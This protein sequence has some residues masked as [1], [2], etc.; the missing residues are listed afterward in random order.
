MSTKNDNHAWFRSVSNAK[1][2]QTPDILLDNDFIR[3]VYNFLVSWLPHRLKPGGIFPRCHLIENFHV[4]CFC[5]SL[6]NTVS[7]S[8]TDDILKCSKEMRIREFLHC[9]YISGWVPFHVMK[10]CLLDFST[11]GLLQEEVEVP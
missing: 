2:L 9:F 4:I 3:Q 6:T 8:E 1:F 10:E 11:K 7:N 5:C